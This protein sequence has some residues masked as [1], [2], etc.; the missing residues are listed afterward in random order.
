M[1]RKTTVSLL[2]EFSSGVNNR[3]LS[4]ML[5]TKA[6][7][8]IA[9]NLTESEVFS[10]VLKDVKDLNSS[11]KI[12]KV[13]ETIEKYSKFESSPVVSVQTMMRECGLSRSIR[14]IKESASYSD[15]I[16]KTA[17]TRIEEG[18]SKVPEFK[19]IPNFIETLKQ[20]SYD[21]TIKAA[22]TEAFEFMQKN[23]TKLVILNSI[24]EMKAVPSNA[25]SS[26]VSILE[27][28]L[29]DN[30]YTADA[31]SMK[32]REQVNIPAVKT[33]ISNLSLMEGKQNKSFNLGL[34]N[35]NVMVESVIAPS[36]TS[37]GKAIVLLN[38]T[39]YTITES[40]VKFMEQAE[41]SQSLNEFYAFCQNFVR[42]GFKPSNGGIKATNLRNIEFEMKNEGSD[43]SMYLNK[44]KIE[45][46]KNI[47]YSS[48]FIMENGGSRQF[49]AS[50][51][52][53]VKYINSMDFIKL[54]VSES[55]SAYLVNLS[56]SVFVIENGSVPTIT[57]MT[58]P[59]LHKYV[60]ENFKYDT[61][62]LYETELTDLEKEISGIDKE[63]DELTENIEKLE[64]SIKTLDESLAKNLD[65][66]DAAKVVDLKF[67]I[68]K[69]IIAMKDKYIAL[70]AKK[71]KLFE[72]HT[73]SSNKTYKIHEKVR[74]KDG[75]FGEVNGVDTH[76][77]RYMIKTEDGKIK[78]YKHSDI[79]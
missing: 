39:L 55:K 12:E 53:N 76:A 40:E 37:N 68:E 74:L 20:F 51:F 21:P 58:Q 59:Q 7:D 11:L 36:V 38:G 50:V 13:N 32:L 52:E 27:Q 10:A 5:V 70:E 41:K 8:Y 66:E 46:A 16:V 3:T 9:Q 15:P 19:F 17:I 47:N 48:L 75:R 73:V 56:D 77:G 61:R 72:T 71:K 6:N 67:V 14:A 44:Q 28:A 4:D 23:S 18:L 35:T 31:L 24:Y 42:L 57:K 26:V 54:L 33:L 43:L 22:V 45:D 25:Y 2:K 60:L 34:G 78:P 63:R 29:I 1:N 79:E 49:L 62:A 65:E 64:G 30:L 69:Q